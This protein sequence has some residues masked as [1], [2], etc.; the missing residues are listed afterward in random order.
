M[1]TY[2]FDIG[3]L[4]RANSKMGPHTMHQHSFA[5]GFARI[6]SA[7]VAMACISGAA[8]AAGYTLT[9]LGDLPGGGNRS[10]AYGLNDLGQVV[11]VSWS[12]AG[13]FAFYWDSSSGMANLGDLNGNEYGSIAYDINNHGVV[14]GGEFGNSSAFS[15]NK[16]TGMAA[17]GPIYYNGAYGINKS[18]AV[19]GY[20]TP[21]PY[22]GYNDAVYWDATGAI[23]NI[24]SLPGESA[25]GSDYNYARAINDLG[26]V[27]GE[28]E[29]F[30]S[31]NGGHAFL[32]S[33]SN[34]TI[35]LGTISGDT[36]S[37]ATDINNLGEA[38]GRSVRHL[39]S[40][41]FI[42]DRS[43]GLQP[44]GFMPGDERSAA[45]AINDLGQVV[46]SSSGPSGSRAF[47]WDL[48][49][50]FQDLN[51][52]IDP[53]L[54]AF[55]ESATDINASG[56]IVGYGTIDGY[57]QA[58]LLTPITAAVPIPAA[59]PLLLGGIGLLAGVARKRR[60]A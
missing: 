43:R 23:K 59:L 11:G 6:A 41:A 35:D 21:S 13:N 1:L 26:Q 44:L 38:V 33:T 55:L 34:G 24:D 28:S 4:V 25:N 5:R 37:S 49:G 40:Q 53:G 7:A 9:P 12:S 45:N 42:W 60:A 22:S 50:G 48:I 36:S 14:V 54:G 46:G 29:T 15:W 32:W 51:D 2:G 31:L 52:L 3:F 30:G 18:G 57:T 8:Q 47:L 20:N 19:A 39:G 16:T 58:F 27:V 17:L 10:Y 56:Q